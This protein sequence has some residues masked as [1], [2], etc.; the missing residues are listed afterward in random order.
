MLLF[1]LELIHISKAFSSETR[2]RILQIIGHESLSA[3]EVFKR[4]NI[5]YDNKKH[6]ESIY[7]DLE[8]LLSAGLLKKNYEE[9]DKQI[10]YSMRF[11][12]ILINLVSG[13]VKPLE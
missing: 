10:V 5:R 9:A 2:I 7:R 12:E 4:Y 1:L 6:R 3:I 11:G 13:K 8:I